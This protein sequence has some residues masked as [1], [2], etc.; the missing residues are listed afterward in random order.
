MKKRLINGCFAIYIVAALLVAHSSLAAY[1]EPALLSA[2]P[3]AHLETLPQTPG[4]H[5]GLDDSDTKLNIQTPRARISIQ[6]RADGERKHYRIVVWT[7]SWC[8]PC[9]TYKKTEIPSLLK[10][11]YKVEVLDYD[12]D[13]PP[14]SITSVPTVVLYYR[15]KIVKTKVYWKARDLDQ[16]VEGRLT[17]KE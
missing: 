1:Q 6:T 3:Q 14:A 16:F 8:G 2:H 7:A 12:R 4:D 5:R 11:G 13:N 17:L 9:Q 15:D 10:A